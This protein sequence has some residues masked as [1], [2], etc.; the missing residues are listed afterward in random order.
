MTVQPSTSYIPAL[1]SSRYAS[2]DGN[3][4]PGSPSESEA[5]DLP[6]EKERVLNPKHLKCLAKNNIDFDIA[7]CQN[8]KEPSLQL[9]YRRYR[10]VND[11]L[12]QVHQLGED[13]TWKG[14]KLTKTE[15]ISLFVAKST[16]HE[17]YR[18]QM[19]AAETQEQMRAWLAGEKDGPSDADIWGDVQDYYSLKDLDSWLEQK[20][21][22]K[23]Q[24]VKKGM[25]KDIVKGKAKVAASQRKGQGKSSEAE[26]QVQAKGKA[27]VDAPKAAKTH[28]KKSST[29]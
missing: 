16:W 10:V 1:A 6:K 27:K 5:S 18:V 28:K 26:K 2:S 14:A 19:P 17:S 21:G 29:G 25:G 20:L 13:K 9:L 23:K 22:K 11:I 8:L 24:V 4:R 12:R 3:S 15:I 7:L